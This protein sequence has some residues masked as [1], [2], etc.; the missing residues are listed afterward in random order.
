LVATLNA[1]FAANDVRFHAPEPARWLVGCGTRQT[2]M[3]HPPARVIGKPLLGVLPQGADGERWRSWQNEIQMLLF[4]HPVNT[5]REAAGRAVVN[6]VWFWGG[7]ALA[8]SAPARI[9]ALYADAWMPRELAG[10]TGV[11][12]MNVPGSLDIL[13]D[14]SEQSPALVWLDP[15]AGTESARLGNWLGEL[16]RDW[17]TPARGAFHNGTIKGLEIVV[18][19]RSKAVRFTGKRL[20][21][22]RRLRTWR[23]APRLSA[24]LAPHL[25]A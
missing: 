13:R 1:H 16:D 5:A 17:A 4:E 24:L 18:V 19:G 10:A 8:P 6:S 11:S 23:S 12:C 3:T 15:P 20:S 7:G 22:A 14:K 2:L 21:L 9:A 25:E